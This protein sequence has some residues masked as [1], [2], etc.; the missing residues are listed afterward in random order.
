MAGLKAFMFET[1]SG[2]QQTFRLAVFRTVDHG[3]V[4]EEAMARPGRRRVQGEIEGKRKVVPMLS[5][6]T[7]RM[8]TFLARC[9]CFGSSNML[10]T[11][12]KEWRMAQVEDIHKAVG[13]DI[14]LP[15]MRRMWVVA[16]V[17]DSS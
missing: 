4:A 13:L 9:T 12:G 3:S 1:T 10:F 14:K 6:S 15:E 2:Y 16:S 8:S 11:Y 7:Q 5:S 17:R